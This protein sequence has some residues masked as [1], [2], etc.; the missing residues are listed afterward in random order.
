MTVFVV[1]HKEIPDDFPAGYE[2]IQVGAEGKKHFSSFSD[3]SGDN[4]SFKNPNY[5]ELT[6]QYWIWKNYQ[7]DIVGL[8]HYRRFFFSW[9]KY[10]LRTLFGIKTSMI[11]EKYILDILRNHDAI[12]TLPSF[13][14]KT[15]RERY[16][17]SH[18]IEDLEKA[19]KAIQEKYPDYI[20]SFNTV[21]NGRKYHYGNMIICKKEL[22]DSYSEW[23]FD[24]L[25]EVEKDTDLS[26][27]VP[28]QQRA[29]G[30]L[31]ERL[32]DVFLLANNVKC[33]ELPVIVTDEPL[34]I[35]QTIRFLKRKIKRI[36]VPPAK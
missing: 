16:A 31:S 4:I 5:C 21:M 12:V 25:F 14:S 28:Y 29:Y 3:D 8:C 6:A 11:P 20:E 30:F 24:I 13:L 32:M 19:E 23:L 33:K 27:R 34:L 17:I 9:P 2:I 7:D 22:F 35:V 36:F 10:L 26:N 18:Y 15:V 1:T